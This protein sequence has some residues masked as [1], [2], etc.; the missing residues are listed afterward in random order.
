MKKRQNLH[1]YIHTYSITVPFLTYRKK[2]A[3]PM[4]LLSVLR[5]MPFCVQKDNPQKHSS[6]AGLMRQAKNEAAA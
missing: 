4:L 1:T 5:G 6:A 2:R 3:Y